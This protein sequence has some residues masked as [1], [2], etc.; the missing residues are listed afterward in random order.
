MK[1][2]NGQI[3]YSNVYQ[4]GVVNRCQPK[5]KYSDADVEHGVDTDAGRRGARL[6]RARV[7]ASPA[8]KYSLPWIKSKA[9]T[10]RDKAINLLPAAGGVVGGLVGGAASPIPII[11]APGTAA[12]G[13][14]AGGGLGAD[15]RQ[16]MTEH[17]HPEDKKMTAKESAKDIGKEAGL[18]GAS[19][20]LPGLVAKVF[21]PASAVD[22]LSFVGNLGPREDIAP[23]LSE[24]QQTERMAGNQVKT[25]GDYLNV[26]DQ[27]KNRIGT[28][29]GASLKTPVQTK[30]G[31]DASWC[32]GS[33]HDASIR[34]LDKSCYKAS[35]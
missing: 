27:T 7:S 31:K 22:K 16:W 9:M 8:P 19:E 3:S 24:L 14:A 13:A 10:L 32:D 26:I 2:K 33:R 29:V 23:A 1:L 18:Q 28:E 30:V 15:V 5:G 6:L 21:R 11:G 25:V 17:F 35:E 4:R 12:V 34:R 20:L